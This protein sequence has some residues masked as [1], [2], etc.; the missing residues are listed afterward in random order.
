M[1][2]GSAVTVVLFLVSDSGHGLSAV[3]G[4]TAPTKLCISS[5][6]AL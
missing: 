4:T 2:P 3:D 1:A 6:L 5:L